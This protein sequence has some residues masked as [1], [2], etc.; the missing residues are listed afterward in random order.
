MV[1]AEQAGTVMT[2]M[3]KAMF[4]VTIPMDTAP[5]G[6]MVA[7]TVGVPGA[8]VAGTVILGAVVTGADVRG[9]V[10]GGVVMVVAGVGVTGGAGVVHPAARSRKLPGCRG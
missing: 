7:D 10:V 2:D 4:F 9:T 1:T 8:V 5:G 3:L 6:V